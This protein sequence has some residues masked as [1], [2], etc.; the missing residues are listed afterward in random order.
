MK[1]QYIKVFRGINLRVP[2]NVVSAD[3]IAAMVKAWDKQLYSFASIKVL[4]REG[5]N[6]SSGYSHTN[7]Q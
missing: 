2:S 1:G 5:S 7:V 4:E 3:N 6:G